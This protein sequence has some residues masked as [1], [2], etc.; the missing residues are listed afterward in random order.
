MVDVMDYP[1]LEQPRGGAMRMPDEVAAM[2]HL[3]RIR[4]V[5]TACCDVR[6]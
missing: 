6:S 1:R 2:L 4:P 3:H 5:N